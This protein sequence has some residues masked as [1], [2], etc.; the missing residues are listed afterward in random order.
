M[1]KKKKK[2]EIKIIKKIKTNK[3][4]KIN[5]KAIRNVSLYSQF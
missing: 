3:M 2:T 1:K 5:Y 4:K